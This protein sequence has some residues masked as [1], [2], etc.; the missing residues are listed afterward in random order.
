MYEAASTQDSLLTAMRPM[1]GRQ[2]KLEDD[3][4]ASDTSFASRGLCMNVRISADLQDAGQPLLPGPAAAMTVWPVVTQNRQQSGWTHPTT[5]PWLQC[6]PAAGHWQ[7]AS[8]APKYLSKISA[9]RLW[10]QHGCLVQMKQVHVSTSP[11][12][13]KHM[14]LDSPGCP[15]PSASTAPFPHPVTHQLLD[16][17]GN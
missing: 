10:R 16:P 8:K 14:T 6:L 3:L 1:L 2:G 9:C 5:W 13:M 12:K 4:L 11:C 17:P 7:P 15:P